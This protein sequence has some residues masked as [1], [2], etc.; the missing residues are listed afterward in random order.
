M[1]VTVTA[2]IHHPQEVVFRTAA[3][4]EKEIEWDPEM[5]AVEKL[6]DGPLGKG[7]RYRGKFKGFGTIEYEF[8]EFDEPRRFIHQARV[9]IGTFQAP[10]HL[11]AGERGDQSDPGGRALVER[12]R[13]DRLAD[14][15]VDAG[16]AIPAD[17]RGGRFVPPVE[18]RKLTTR[19]GATQSRERREIWDECHRGPGRGLMTQRS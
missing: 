13:V 5:K 7:S 4:P 9:A 15:E 1:R 6:T 11:R 8:A 14:G 16:E 10:V 17:R 3:Y 18:E 19:E 2:T 12:A